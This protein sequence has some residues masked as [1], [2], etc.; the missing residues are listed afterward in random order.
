MDFAFDE[1][2]GLFAKVVEEGF[3][4]LLVGLCFEHDGA[5][6]FVADPAG[7]GVAGGDGGGACS[8]SDAL[9]S[10]LEDDAL[11]GDHGGL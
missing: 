10:A 3:E 5:V 4:D 11:A 8:E 2:G 9:D 7:D 1:S 6:G